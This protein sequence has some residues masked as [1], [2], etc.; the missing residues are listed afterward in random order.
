MITRPRRTISLLAGLLFGGFTATAP[1][2]HAQLVRSGAGAAAAT[3][4]RD[5][6]RLDLGGGTTAGANGLFSDATG[7]R[8]EINWDGVPDGFAAPNNLP[9]N[10]FNVNSPRGAV[11]GT[12]GTGF[13]V[14]A[15]AGVAP[16][17]FGNIDPSYSTT[18][19]T[20]SPQRLFTALG[21][22]V[23]DVN[24]FLPGTTTPALTRGFGSIFSDVDLP[25][26]TSIE[27]FGPAGTSLGT[28]FAPNVVGASQTLSFLG[29]S[30]ATPLIS[31]VR[32]TNGNGA[33]GAGLLDENGNPRD[34]VVMDDFLY[35]APVAT[36]E[37]ASWAL[38]ASGLL[39]VAAVAR[40]RGTHA[41]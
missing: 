10:F 4:A 41:V 25:N 26:Q 15:N 1:P 39:A 40:R 14:S 21:S 34:L 32:I 30:F 29:V 22:N 35:G 3:A 37:P 18:F 2:L 17:N 6:F 11:F 19:V 31:R 7:A 9:A 16:I 38:V 36:P 27:L 20:F 28:F 23:V 12:P 33:L 8:R 13:Q 24:F 5:Q